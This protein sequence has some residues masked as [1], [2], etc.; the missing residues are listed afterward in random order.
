MEPI[1]DLNDLESIFLSFQNKFIL[2]ESHIRSMSYSNNVTY[3]M[4]VIVY[5]KMNA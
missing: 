2:K 5:S 1:Y 3:V 4:H